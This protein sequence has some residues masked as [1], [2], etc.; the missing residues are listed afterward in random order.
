MNHPSRGFTLVE[1]VLAT[2]I[3]LAVMAMTMESLLTAQRYRGWSEQQ[4]EVQ[5]R[6][7]LVTNQMTRDISTSGW[8]FPQTEDVNGNG[9]LDVGEDL[10]GNG[11]LS[12]VQYAS[13]SAD[14]QMR[15]YPFVTANTAAARGS[16]FV[17]RQDPAGG[18][19]STMSPWSATTYP[20][21]TSTQVSTLA[22][23]LV[24]RMRDAGLLLTPD[25]AREMVQPSN[26]LIF[27]RVATGPWQAD[28]LEMDRQ[29]LPDLTFFPGY[30]ASQVKASDVQVTRAN[31]STYWRTGGSRAYDWRQLS[32]WDNLPKDS[33]GKNLVFRPS[34]W[35]DDGSGNFVH[36][37][38][39]LPTTDPDYLKPYGAPAWGAALD[40]GASGPRLRVQWETIT[41][42][43]M[44]VDANAGQ[45]DNQ[46]P[47]DLRE[48]CYAVIASPS[49]FG[50]L[51]RAHAVTSSGTP[52]LGNQPGEWI[53][54]PA[55]TR[56]WQIDLVLSDDVVRVTWTTRRH[57][58]AL[59]ANQVRARIVLAR[60]TH[61]SVNGLRQIEWRI[62]ERNLVMEARNEYDDQIAAAE[63]I[64]VATANNIP[65]V[66]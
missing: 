23:S 6:L 62:I 29:S 15:Y 39:Q 4:D 1:V 9:T 5:E 32:N 21:W 56:G 19:F 22:A 55:A 35:V 50:R 11:A 14:R 34:A 44:Y 18:N 20:G 64:D 54:A 46:A 66:Y 31:G 38:S 13:V 7:D 51:V 30:S 41:E 24:D 17:S 58:K 26:E 33:A 65:F 28:P 61:E 36:I 48:F 40:D 42:N 2:A 47:D 43:R 53:S 25:L 3:F 16:A 12:E 8:F 37:N 45:D 10:D 60:P 63:L 49:G 59:S 52:V 27:L 57:D